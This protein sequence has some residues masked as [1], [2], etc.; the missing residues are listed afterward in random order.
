MDEDRKESYRSP[1]YTKEEVNALLNIIENY[2]SIILN[3]STST[4]AS[5]AKDRAWNSIAKVFN[6]Q[7]F[8]HI[9]SVESIK[10][11]W[12]NL[13]KEARKAAKNIMIMKHY[14]NDLWSRV[15]TM[16]LEHEK[17]EDSKPSLENGSNEI[18]TKDTDNATIMDFEECENEES[19]SSDGDMQTC[20]SNRSLNFLPQECT[21]LLKCVREEKNNI[22]IK[23]TNSKTNLLKNSAWTRIAEAFNK[24]N[25]QKR[26][27]KV[28]RTKF[29]N[30]K[31]AAKSVHMKQ[32]LLNNQHEK[33]K[34][35]TE[36]L[37]DCKSDSDTN[38]GNL[39]DNVEMDT[40]SLNKNKYLDIDPLDT[41]I[42]GDCGNESKH[43]YNPWCTQDSKLV[44]KLKLQ[45]FNY[46]LET[47]KMERKR[48]ENAMQ[49]EVAAFE[50]NALE[51]SLKLRAARLEVIAAQAKLPA[52]HPGLLF[53]DEEKPAQE[54]L[55]RYNHTM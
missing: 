50:S 55:E 28:L 24:Q 51:R 7:G 20:R 5:H 33:E 8:K 54:Y 41:V 35:K 43:P 45:L 12:D 4:A 39:N 42:N 1:V 34:I 26:S 23:E 22:F 53:T 48:V 47:A 17:N 27:S 14:D 15:V 6:K 52:N 2:K 40:L 30:M 25:P 11:K 3:K 16:L 44:E 18:N 46:Q 29:D 9:R 10:T 36:P 49:A 31:K 37:F 21:L 19:D 38:D 32:Y 13:K